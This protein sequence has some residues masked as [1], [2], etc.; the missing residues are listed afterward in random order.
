MATLDPQFIE[1]IKAKLLDQQKKIKEELDDIETKK[2]KAK[3]PDYG[4]KD[5]ENAQEVSTFVTRISVSE[6]LEKELRDIEKALSEIEKDTYG[7]C[8]YCKEPI[9]TRRLDARPTST[10]CVSCKIKLKSGA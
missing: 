9:D 3:L 8:K 10:S 7:I 6:T 5:D 2:G 4:D 1:N